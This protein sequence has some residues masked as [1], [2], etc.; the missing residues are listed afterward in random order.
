MQRKHLC[1]KLLLFSHRR[2]DLR[3]FDF[4]GIKCVKTFMCVCVCS[5]LGYIYFCPNTEYLIEWGSPRIKRIINTKIYGFGNGIFVCFEHHA[6]DFAP[7]GEN[8]HT[9]H[10]STIINYDKLYE[11]YITQSICDYNTIQTYELRRSRQM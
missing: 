7:S 3:T 11:Y 9:S 4:I 8:T 6:V 10:Q 1:L 2:R 5:C